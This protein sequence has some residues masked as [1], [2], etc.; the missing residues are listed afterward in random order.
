[1]GGE[2]AQNL[3]LQLIC[4]NEAF[5]DATCATNDPIPANRVPYTA[6]QLANGFAIDSPYNAS[7]PYDIK[8]F[9]LF[10]EGSYR[11]GQFKATAGARYYNFK[12]TRD[13]VSG[14]CLLGRQHQPGRPTKSNG[15]SPRFILSYEP[16]RSFSVNLQAAKG[17]RLGGT[18]D[19]LNV[20]LCTDEDLDIFGGQ[21]SYK[22]ETLWNYE[23][24][25]KYSRGPITFNSAIFHNE[26]RDLQVTQTAG[27]CSSR[28]VFNVPKAH[29]TGIEAE[30]TAHP[31][32]GLTLSLAANIQSAEFDSTVLTGTGAVLGGIEEGNR[33]PTVPKIQLAATATYGQRFRDNARLVCDRQ[34]PAYRQSLRRARRPGVGR[35]RPN[36]CGRQSGPVL[37]PGNGQLRRGERQLRL[38]S[39]AGLHSRQPV[40][41]HGVGQW[42]GGRRL[43]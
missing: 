15:I 16:N 18:N 38:A 26:I 42:V 2:D 37:R 5:V 10:G 33:L 12:E 20:P 43:R 3:I 28:I 39:P 4:F 31:L 23:A 40:G 21:G 6:G 30:F 8:Q 27:S 13:F 29:S 25:V 9:A 24:G 34:R 41:R 14:G 35:R 36:G 22:D 32:E 19:P 1:M 7:L 11:F 17:F